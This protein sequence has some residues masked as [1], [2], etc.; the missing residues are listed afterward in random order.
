MAMTT[1]LF[2]PTCHLTFPFKYRLERHLKSEDHLMFVESQ[3]LLEQEDD[4]DLYEAIH[5]VL[6]INPKITTI[7]NL[8]PPYQLDV[9]GGKQMG[10]D[11]EEIYDD[12]GDGGDS[13]GG[14]SEGSNSEN[15][16]SGADFDSCDG[17]VMYASMFAL[18][19]P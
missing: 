6:T 18:S 12:D 10:P 19:L 13:E 9:S 8:T 7:L 11:G 3:K 17:I 14:D 16:D 15:F 2:C 4:Q 5:K 1:E